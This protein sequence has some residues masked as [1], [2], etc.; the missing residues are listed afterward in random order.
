VIDALYESNNTTDQGYE[1]EPPTTASTV[2]TLDSTPMPAATIIDENDLSKDITD[3][4]TI[5]EQCEEPS[6]TKAQ[7]DNDEKVS[8]P[9]KRQTARERKLLAK[10]RQKEQQRE[11]K[12]Q[13]AIKHAAQSR[14]NDTH[15]AD[16]DTDT[17]LEMKQLHI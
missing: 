9:P 7:S 5:Q 15:K 3:K 13:S 14:K 2:D 11:K 16:A 10:I 1:N 12:Q 17:N 8:P 6:S 4:L